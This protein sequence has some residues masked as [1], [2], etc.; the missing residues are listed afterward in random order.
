MLIREREKRR[1]RRERGSIK[2]T[3]TVSETCM[4][5]MNDER[6]STMMD[7]NVHFSLLL[8]NIF[9]E[10]LSLLAFTACL[11]N[12]NFLWNIQAYSEN[13]EK[14]VSIISRSL[15]VDG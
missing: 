4:N 7:L 10:I 11:M 12:F 5:R 3:Q 13:Q 14:N 1:R 2:R 9:F 15:S 6:I 8:L